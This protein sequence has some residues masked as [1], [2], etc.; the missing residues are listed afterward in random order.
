M[1][2]LTCNQGHSFEWPG[3]TAPIR[4]TVCGNQIVPCETCKGTGINSEGN[5][6]SSNRCPDCHG[7]GKVWKT[8]PNAV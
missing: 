6:F 5:R 8:V 4:C 1:S 2:I 7:R 3:P